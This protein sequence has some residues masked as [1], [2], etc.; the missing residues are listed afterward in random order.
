MNS[1][2]PCES[3]E[4]SITSSNIRILHDV[5]FLILAISLQVNSNERLILIFSPS[6]KDAN[7]NSSRYLDLI[8]S[9]KFSFN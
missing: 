9:S 8:D 6:E 5:E 4:E 2:V 1:S 7:E 3:S